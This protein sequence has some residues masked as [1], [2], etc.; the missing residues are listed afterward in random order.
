MLISLL[1]FLFII[2]VCVMVHEWGH[3][4]TA[5]LCGVQVHE[6]AFGMGPALWQRRG[7]RNLWSFR[8]FPVGG[9]VRLAGMG[10]ENDEEQVS[11]GMAFLEKSP[12]KRLIILSA[13]SFNN[14]V[15][16][17]LLATGILW[18]NGILDLSKTEV[19][20]VIAGY[21]A[22]Q[23]GLQSGDVL[24]QVNGVT[25][26]DWKSMTEE[27]AMAGKSS[28]SAQLLI[29][30]GDEEF[31]LDLAT[32]LDS[33]SKRPLIGITPPLRRLSFWKAASQSLGYTFEMSLLMIKG[34]VQMVAHPTRADIA[35]PV[36]IATMAGDA[37]EAGFWPLISFLAMISLNL[38]I[39][40][41]L[42]FPA[43]DG[44][45]IL[46]VLIEMILRKPLSE[47][48]EGR[49]HFA[50]FL[51]LMALILLVTWKDILRIVGTNQ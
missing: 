36:G 31:S 38:G 35:G 23:A 32:K 8:A 20:T 46:F 19:G 45:R 13:G 40:N 25:V 24:L 16:V 5:I 1:A 50:G 15:L 4:I 44:G 7:K 9:F 27:I 30:R 22:E 3:Y 49:I 39:L 33:A 2:L 43:L 47:E 17:V 51:I 6:F 21:P 26:D 34:L 42:P 10:E 11:P 12:W 29:R 28:G 41:L 37:A 14:I 18:Y 48:V